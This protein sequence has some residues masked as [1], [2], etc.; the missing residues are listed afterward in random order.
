MSSNYPCQNAKMIPNSPTFDSHHV[1]DFYFMFPQK[2]CGDRCWSTDDAGLTRRD[3]RRR[4]NS[5]RLTADERTAAR[6]KLV[7]VFGSEFGLRMRYV[8]ALKQK[9]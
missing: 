8:F 2:R 7:D 6:E 3:L 5:G 9:Q 1:S 4:E